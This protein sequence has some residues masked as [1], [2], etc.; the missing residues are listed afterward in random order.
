MKEEKGFLRREVKQVTLLG[1]FLGSLVV[2]QCL[3]LYSDFDG[4]LSRSASSEAT[5][6]MK[7]VL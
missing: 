7:T 4:V 2:D 5:P 3:C 1:Y 6:E